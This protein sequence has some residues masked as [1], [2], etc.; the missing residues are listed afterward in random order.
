MPN[1]LLPLPRPDFW[2]RNF[3][4]S[5]KRKALLFVL[6]LFLLLFG[7]YTEQIYLLLDRFYYSLAS[8]VSFLSF[9]HTSQAE[10]SSKITMRS[11]PT[12]VTYGLI[13]TALSFAILHV[14]FNNLWK[15]KISALFYLALFVLCLILIAAGKFIPGMAWA[16][17]LCRRLIEM[18]VSPFPII[19]LLA[20]FAGFKKR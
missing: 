1:Q 18:I 2:Q 10:V 4:F 9:L 19:L 5:Y 13:Y 17:L 14:Y 20:V 11:W 12:M 3:A 16:Y 8:R 6:V 15:T 7:I